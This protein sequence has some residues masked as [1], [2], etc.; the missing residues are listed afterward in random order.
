M[1]ITTLPAAL[2][3]D[4]VAALFFHGSPSRLALDPDSLRNLGAHLSAAILA[5]T[6]AL[7]ADRA[8]TE[9]TV[10][11]VYVSIAARS[12][13]R[14]DYERGHGI[15]RRLRVGCTIATIRKHPHAAQFGTLLHA[16]TTERYTRGQWDLA[17]RLCAEVTR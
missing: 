16:L 3:L 4:I 12:D 6:A 5:A 15:A 13:E 10:R 8:A 7:G 17:G 1:S 14:A 9:E 11:L 2:A